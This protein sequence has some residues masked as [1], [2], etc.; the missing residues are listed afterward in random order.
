MYRKEHQQCFIDG[1]TEHLL[2]CQTNQ[3]QCPERGS[4]E[5]KEDKH[6]SED[7]LKNAYNY[8]TSGVYTYVLKTFIT[9]R[10][11]ALI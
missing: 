5:Y 11:S 4:A 3:L 7:E 9:N 2:S 8:N 10:L 1:F 6:P